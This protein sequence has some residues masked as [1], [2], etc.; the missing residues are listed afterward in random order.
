ME[1][2]YI[3]V[4]GLNK[5]LKVKIDRDIQLQNILIKGEISNF[6]HHTSGH[7]YFTL[8]D[9]N[10]RINAV[11]FSSKTKNLDFEL[12]EGMNVL[13]SASLSVYEVAGT[14]QLYINT[15]EQ[16]GI[17]SLF[18]QFEKRKMKLQ[19]EGLFDSNTK[20]IIPKYPQKI[21]VLS[22]Y[23]SAALMDILRTIKNRFP[24]VRVI[25]FAIP[26]QGKDAHIEIEK[27]LKYVDSLSFSSIILSRGGGSIE[28][29]WNFNE[30]A[31]A[32][33][34][35]DCKTPIISGIGHEID[36]TICDF[37][38]DVRAATPTA[39]ATI[40]TPDIQELKRKV[41][42]LQQQV[43]NN[44]NTKYKLAK[45]RL[46]NIQSFYLFNNPAKM[47]E[48]KKMYID[49]LDNQMKQLMHRKLQLSIQKLLKTEKQFNDIKQNFVINYKNKVNQYH[50][51]LNTNLKNLVQLKTHRFS[52]NVAKLDALSPLH[53][54]QRG[55]TI[56]KKD[57]KAITTSKALNSGDRIS[58][59]FKDGDI[60]AKIE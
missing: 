53:V 1:K 18:L 47:F 13:V 23:P 57:Q 4:S 7:L 40:A 39:A 31:L 54:L 37:V 22:A 35:Y 28:D 19:S 21:A 38:A 41:V 29:L 3:T 16:D 33:A 8:K 9:N 6:K 42:I 55:Y 51:Q 46:A 20:K 30:E 58:I 56:I 48:S 27:T 60:H 34:I 43:E 5:Y 15:M 59:T 45:N 26:V 50:I 2:K 12:K 24:V 49:S 17:G 36:F 11:M 10:S 25:V 32:R 14:Y 44:F 52:M